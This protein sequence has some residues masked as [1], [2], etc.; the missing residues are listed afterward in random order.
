TFVEIQESPTEQGYNYDRSGD[1][2][3]KLNHQFD[4]S[5]SGQHNHALQLSSIPIVVIN[6][7]AYREFLLDSNESNASST[8]AQFISLDAL[9]IYQESSGNLGV[10]KVGGVPPQPGDHPFTPGSG[11]GVSGEHL[12]YNM[13]GSDLSTWVALNSN[14][15]SGSGDSD[16]RLLVPNAL[17]DNSPFVYLYSHFGGQGPDWVSESGFEEWGVRTPQANVAH[18]SGIKFGDTNDNGVKDP[19]EIGL[20]GW[21]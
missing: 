18:L 3:A 4:E 17:F 16:I 9:Q 20:G 5:T 12:V 8:N 21:T 19:G 14:L 7:V 6:N 1:F 2:G 11:F 10:Q 15:S 13:D